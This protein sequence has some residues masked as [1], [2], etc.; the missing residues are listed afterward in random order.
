[1]RYINIKIVKLSHEMVETLNSLYESFDMCSMT[2]KKYQVFL[3]G[4]YQVID[5]G[6]YYKPAWLHYGRKTVVFCDRCNRVNISECFGYKNF[7]LCLPCANELTRSNHDCPRQHCH[8][9]VAINDNILQY[10]KDDYEDLN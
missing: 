7:D 8:G 6:K 2:I 5:H 3:Y 9:T 1:M 10:Q 4:Y